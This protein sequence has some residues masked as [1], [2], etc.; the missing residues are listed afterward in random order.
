LRARASRSNS[1]YDLAILLLV[2]YTG[3]HIKLSSN[4]WPTNSFWMRV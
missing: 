4:P 1:Q 3:R 2:V